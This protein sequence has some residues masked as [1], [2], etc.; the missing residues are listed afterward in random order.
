MRTFERSLLPFTLISLFLASWLGLAGCGAAEKLPEFTSDLGAP[1]DLFESPPDLA[2]ACAPRASDGFVAHFHPPHVDNKACTPAEVDL[3]ISDWLRGTAS[4]RAAFQQGHAGCFACAL[5]DDDA[6]TTAPM[7]HH[8]A[9]RFTDVNVPACIAAVDVDLNSACAAHMQ[10]LEQCELFACT[11]CGKSSLDEINTCRN[12]VC[13]T[14][15]H[16]AACASTSKY[17]KCHAA[18]YP[19]PDGL[20]RAM[21]ATFCG[22]I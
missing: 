9:L 3:F 15:A 13:A 12:D 14:F 6:S 1:A 19:A 2:P 21:V 7:I 5:S 17:A 20:E 11:G 10:A 22:S 16:D 8:A 18:A 4:Q